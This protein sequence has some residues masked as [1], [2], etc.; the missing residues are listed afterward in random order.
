[1]NP[2]D[3]PIDAEETQA[4]SETTQAS[5]PEETPEA[6]GA[7]DA[8]GDS[9]GD[10]G[11]DEA[12]VE[13]DGHKFK[14]EKDA[15]DWALKNKSQLEHERAIA[16]AYR[17]GIQ[18]AATSTH[19][20]SPQLAPKEEPEITEEQFYQD[21]VGTLQKVKA[22]ATEKAR[23]ELNQ[24]LS[25][26]E[27]ERQVWD[28][29]SSIHPD[30]ADFKTDVELIANSAEHLPIVQAL[31]RTKGP[32]AGY[33]YVAQK[34]RAKFQAY[35]EATK[36]KTVLPRGGGGG[37]TPTGAQKSVTLP[38]KEEKILSM[39]E[40]VRQYKSRFTTKGN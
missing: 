11:S 18:D 4:A 31:V 27:V 22:S 29:F 33:D 26:R 17:T 25:Q 3:T 37:A 19:Q 35:M 30:L 39:R 23:R 24:E 8:S 34:T 12:A 28:E 20:Q 2:Q 6:A 21:P 16:D 7:S 36:S 14:S 15:L 5:A 10:A 9:S 38:K 32:K 1:M 13:I 40:Q